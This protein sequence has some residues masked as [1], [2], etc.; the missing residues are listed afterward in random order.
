MGS[1]LFETGSA[2]FTDSRTNHKFTTTVLGVDAQQKRN[3]LRVHHAGGTFASYS[4]ESSELISET[5]LD[6]P[7]RVDD[8]V[9]TATGNA[10]RGASDIAIYMAEGVAVERVRNVQ[11]EYEDVRFK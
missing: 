4:G 2:G 6:C 3:L 1:I 9:S 11:L 10:K 5:H 8:A 7:G